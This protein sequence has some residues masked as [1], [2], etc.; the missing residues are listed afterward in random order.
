MEL[1]ESTVS[2]GITLV[3]STSGGVSW[4]DMVQVIH[5]RDHQSNSH[6]ETR[7]VTENCKYKQQVQLQLASP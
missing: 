1:K 5:S 4:G 3:D 7:S 6:L 2:E